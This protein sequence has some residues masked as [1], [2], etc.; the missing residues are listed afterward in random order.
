MAGLYDFTGRQRLEDGASWIRT[1]TLATGDPDG[2]ISDLVPRD[3]TGFTALLVIRKSPKGNDAGSTEILRITDGDDITLGGAAGTVSWNVAAATMSG[4]D[5]QTG[6][7]A[8]ELTSG[9]G[10]VTRE[11]EGAVEYSRRVNR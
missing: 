3:L 8:L 9:G 4:L 6:V 1:F 7:Y 2:P 11:L 10:D 5:F